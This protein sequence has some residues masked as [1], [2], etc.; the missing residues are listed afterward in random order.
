MHVAIVGGGIVGLSSAYYLSS[1]GA[2]VTVFEKG[3]IGSGNTERSAGG[4]RSQFTLPAN[5]ELSKR[6]LE[7]WDNFEER[8]G[9]DIGFHRSGYLFLA[10]SEASK[11]RFETAVE[12]QR[13]LGVENEFLSPEEV[14][15]IHDGIRP[16]A[17]LGGAY[18]PNDGYA[19]PHLAIQG[20]LH[21]GREA[22]VSIETQTPIVDLLEDDGAIAG[23]RTENE[24]VE[25]D[26]VV[27]AAGAWAGRVAEMADLE[28]PL[29]PRR[30]QV[31]VVEP[32]RPVPTSTPMTLDPETDSYFHP[33]RDGAAIVGGGPDLSGDVTP[34][35]P[36]SYA[37]SMDFD[38]ASDVLEA[39]GQ[40]ADFFGPGAEVKNGWAGLI[41]ETPDH[42]AIIEQ[43]R[44]GLVNAVGFSGHGFLHS[45]AVGQV[46]RD[47][48]LEGETPMI[49]VDAFGSDRFDDGDHDRH[50]WLSA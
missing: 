37:K 41:I 2:D 25:A 44:P 20:F 43:S 45:P 18:S 46:V 23:V 48:V 47:L 49:D 10:R 38:F 3:S 42:N 7:V 14:A 34:D 11:E 5:V 27:N 31:A 19:D 36:D 6:S 16:E 21:A 29:T 33:E 4:I 22:G 30:L 15:E 40:Y 13:E 24:R 1:A 12:L 9:V 28:L 8:F 17:I 32:E 50:R 39:V 26:A 35:D